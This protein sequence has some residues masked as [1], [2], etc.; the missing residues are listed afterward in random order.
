M[1]NLLG[2]TPIFGADI[3]PTFNINPNEICK[4]IKIAK[5]KGLKPKVI[6]PVDLFGL[7]SRHRMIN[8]I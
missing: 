2:A 7:P 6:M 4:A 3:Y 5:S 8:E 1:V